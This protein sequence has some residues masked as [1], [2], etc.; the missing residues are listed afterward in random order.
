MKKI[1]IMI[2]LI[3]A[4]T[5]ISVTAARGG[6]LNGQVASDYINTIVAGTYVP[7]EGNPM[8]VGQHVQIECDNS[9]HN[10]TISTMST[11]IDL[12]GLYG[13][14][15]SSSVCGIGDSVQACTGSGYTECSGWIT[16]EPLGSD[17]WGTA[18]LHVFGV[19]EY[20]T[21]AMAFLMIFTGGGIAYLRNKKR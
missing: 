20:T 6:K 13:K 14:M 11:R 5:S 3:L 21:A 9:T 2:L 10:I 18:F 15:V 1:L 19:P 12:D 16:V 8:P 7:L 17:G 4:I